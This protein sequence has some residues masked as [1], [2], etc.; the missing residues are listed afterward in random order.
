VGQRHDSANGR[1]RLRPRICL[2]KGCGRRYQPRRWNQRYCQ[3]AE[4]L[5][6]VR[7]WQAARRQARRRQDDSARAQHA[8]AERARRQRAPSLPQVPKSAEVA[9]ARGHAADFFCPR[10]CATGRGAMN[11]PQRRVATRRATAALRAVRRCAGCWIV[12]ASGNC[13]ALS[14][15]GVCAPRSTRP[16]ARAAAPRT[17]TVLWQRQHGRRLHDQAKAAPVG[18]RWPRSTDGLAWDEV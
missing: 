1:R 8:E 13:E 14:A 12:N 2:R 10:F 11:R 17:T 4:C 15:A 7:R 16:P 3:D 6:L 9:A 5:R 18:G